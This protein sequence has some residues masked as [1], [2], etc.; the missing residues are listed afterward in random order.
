[1]AAVLE[2]GYDDE[3]FESVVSKN[4]HCVICFNVFKDP[5]MCRDNEHL[6]CRACITKH[7]TNSHTCP[8]CMGELTVDTLR[9][10]P[11]IVT[12]C[13]SEFKIRCEHFNRGCGFIELGKL[14][15]H[16][17]ECG[18]A[19]VVCSND[20]CELE[21]NKRDLIHHETAVCEHR[22]VKCHDC[23]EMR[24]ELNKVNAK[25]DKM[26]ATMCNKFTQLNDTLKEVSDK[27]NRLETVEASVRSLEHNKEIN[28]KA[29]IN[30]VVQ[31]Q[32]TSNKGK[33]KKKGRCDSWSPPRKH[34]ENV[35][36]SEAE[37]ECGGVSWG[38]EPSSWEEEP[39]SWRE[40]PSS[41]G[42]DPL[43]LREEEPSSWG[44][45]R[46]SRWD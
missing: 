44:E 43:L 21:V 24:Q 11:R 13:L 28:K 26:A 45:A 14:E 19:P 34:S 37:I 38:V 20:E 41:W 12:D 15:R 39:S 32:G 6:F 29:Q 18:Y 8:S 25:L 33:S 36:S 42:V 7:L 27:L 40:E 46:S 17:D 9:E 4:Y 2:Q 22:R 23:G 3:R 10:A 30:E 5:V 16:I 35:P 1:M 31:E